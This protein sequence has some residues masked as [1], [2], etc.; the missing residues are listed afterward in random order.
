VLAEYFSEVTI[1]ERDLLND[2]TMQRPGVPHSRHL[3]GL[4]PRG[5][6][7]IEAFFPGIREELL[8]YGAVPLDV[9]TRGA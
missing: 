9:P 3:H 4:L 1:I 6:Q 2:D 8:S 5:L 7:I